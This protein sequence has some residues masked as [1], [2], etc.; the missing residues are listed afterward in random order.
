MWY[1][2]IQIFK[3]SFILK[4]SFPEI[5]IIFSYFPMKESNFSL[6]DTCIYYFCFLYSSSLQFFTLFYSFSLF[7]L[8]SLFRFP[9]FLSSVFD[10]QFID[11]RWKRYSTNIRFL[12]EKKKCFDLIKYS[13][14]IIQISVFKKRATLWIKNIQRYI[15]EWTTCIC[16]KFLT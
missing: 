1:V 16:I 12:F 6:L 14:H 4:Q 9:G 15:Y 5:R 11:I 13:I 10:F 8:F 3:I 7:S 2:L